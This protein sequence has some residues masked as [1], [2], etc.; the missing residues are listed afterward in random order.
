MRTA[1]PKVLVR[2][3]LPWMVTVGMFVA[4]LNAYATYS[5]PGCSKNTA[6]LALN[7]QGVPVAEMVCIPQNAGGYGCF[8]SRY[9]NRCALDDDGQFHCE[10]DVE[11]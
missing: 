2:H 6:F 4:A 1:L 11:L 5:E 10:R 9:L 8:N 3:I 7:A